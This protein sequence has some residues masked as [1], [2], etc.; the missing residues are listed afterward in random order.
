MYILMN[1]HMQKPAFFHVYSK[2]WPGGV[3]LQPLVRPLTVPLSDSNLGQVIQTR[4][5]VH[6]AVY[7]STG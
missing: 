4:A 1:T 5:S 7:S 6:Q 3:I 2:L